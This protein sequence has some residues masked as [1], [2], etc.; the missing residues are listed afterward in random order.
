MTALRSFQHWIKTRTTER[1]RRGN[2]AV[3]AYLKEKASMGV[4]EFLSCETVQG[5]TGYGRFHTHLGE[6]FEVLWP[7]MKR[8]AIDYR[9]QPEKEI[10]CQQLFKGPTW[11]ELPMQLSDEHRSTTVQV[12]FWLHPWSVWKKS[13]GPH[14]DGIPLSNEESRPME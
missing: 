12:V 3:Y 4:L 13:L 6:F 10:A 5:S 11:V 9:L 1:D 7:E 2:D 8:I 14:P